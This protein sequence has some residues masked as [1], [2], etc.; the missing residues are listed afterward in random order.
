MH[1]HKF[2]YC[3]KCGTKVLKVKQL[4]DM[5]LGIPCGCYDEEVEKQDPKIQNDIDLLEEYRALVAGTD[6]PEVTSLD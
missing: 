4:D 2:G 1:K 6:A 3:Q 5:L